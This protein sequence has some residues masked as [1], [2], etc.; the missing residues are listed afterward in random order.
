MCNEWG[1][2][3]VLQERVYSEKE[4]KKQESNLHN[5]T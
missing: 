1:I 3:V 2:C 4:D 5:T